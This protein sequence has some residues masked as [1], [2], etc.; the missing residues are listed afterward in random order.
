V[1]AEAAVHRQPNRISIGG[2][3][4]RDGRRRK[5]WPPKL[6][7]PIPPRPSVPARIRVEFYS[8]ENTLK[9]KLQLYFIKDH[10]VSLYVRS[11]KLILKILACYLYVYRVILDRGPAY[12]NW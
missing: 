1:G 9:E 5:K 6:T 2:R 3:R 4:R 12:A 11:A 7:I 10:T 8:S